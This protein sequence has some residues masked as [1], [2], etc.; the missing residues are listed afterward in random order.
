MAFEIA[1][2]HRKRMYNKMISHKTCTEKSLEFDNSLSQLQLSTQAKRIKTE[3]ERTIWEFF[4]N[5]LA[6]SKLKDCTFQGN[7]LYEIEK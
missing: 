4:F 7:I 3:F 5:E 1:R 2:I 6:P